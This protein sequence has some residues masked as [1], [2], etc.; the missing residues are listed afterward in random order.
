MSIKEF[1]KSGTF[2]LVVLGLVVLLLPFGIE[3][4]G[5][6]TDLSASLRRSG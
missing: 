4:I 2:V 6:A 3:Q 5:E 1:T